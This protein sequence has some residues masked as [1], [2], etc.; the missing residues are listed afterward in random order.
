MVDAFVTF[1]GVVELNAR[2]GGQDVARG[3]LHTVTSVMAKRVAHGGG[4]NLTRDFAGRQFPA[5][6]D[7]EIALSGRRDVRGPDHPSSK[8]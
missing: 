5:D 4:W 6:K 1:L 2:F 3:R 8:T 7:A